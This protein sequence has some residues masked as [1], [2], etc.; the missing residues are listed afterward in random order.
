MQ[1]RIH[2]IKSYIADPENDN[3]NITSGYNR[4][5][6]QR[7]S[8]SSLLLAGK[9]EITPPSDLLNNEQESQYIKSVVA[10]GV[11]ETLSKIRKLYF[12]YVPERVNLSAKKGTLLG[13]S[14]L[15]Q[16]PT[17]MDTLEYVK[18]LFDAT[19]LKETQTQ[20]VD[21]TIESMVSPVLVSEETVQKAKKEALKKARLEALAKRELEQDGPT[22]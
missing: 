18:A 2:P 14:R 22:R 5:S 11:K 21:T 17:K 8:T 16:I 20:L 7:L 12:G 13:A 19:T 9:Y 15:N 6:G 3:E 4:I 10:N 1:S